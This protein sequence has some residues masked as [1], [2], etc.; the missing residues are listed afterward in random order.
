MKNF[1]NMDMNKILAMVL[2]GFTILM[3]I[4]SILL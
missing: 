4:I 1:L 2:F 3:V